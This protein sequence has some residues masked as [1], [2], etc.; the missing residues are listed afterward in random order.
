MRLVAFDASVLTHEQAI[1]FHYSKLIEERNRLGLDLRLTEAE[2]YY[3]SQQLSVQL[4]DT[5]DAGP[6]HVIRFVIPVRANFYGAASPVWQFADEIIENLGG[7]DGFYVP[8]TFTKVRRNSTVSGGVIQY[9]DTSKTWITLGT[10][11]GIT[12]AFIGPLTTL[13]G[14]VGTV[15]YKW[16]LGTSTAWAVIL[17][18]EY[19]A[20]QTNAKSITL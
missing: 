2:G 7:L 3:S 16:V 5:V 19:T 8:T 15:Y 6:C 13:Y 1:L 20:A 4:V 18:A 17:A 11:L 12:A 10:V 9:R 14:M